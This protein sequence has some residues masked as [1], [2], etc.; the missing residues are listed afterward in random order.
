MLNNNFVELSS[1]KMLSISVFAGVLAC[2]VG[3]SFFWILLMY[4]IGPQSDALRQVPIWIM[5]G[6]TYIRFTVAVSFI[7]EPILLGLY[8]YVSY[9]SW[10]MRNGVVLS[11]RYSRAVTLLLVSLLMMFVS[12]I[13]TFLGCARSHDALCMLYGA[14]LALPSYLAFYLSG[15]LL[16]FW[17]EEKSCL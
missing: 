3:V 7:P 12:L 6:V 10:S 4:L 16:V 2:L 5:E 9:W 14:G 8:G 15:L 11:K 17:S 1:K 13:L